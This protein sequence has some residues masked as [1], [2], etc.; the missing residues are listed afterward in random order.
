MKTI[1]SL[2]KFALKATTLGARTMKR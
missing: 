2:M 1:I